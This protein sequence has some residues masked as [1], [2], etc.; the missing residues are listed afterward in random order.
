MLAEPNPDRGKYIDAS[1]HGTAVASMIIGERNGLAPNARIITVMM[2]EGS[3]TVL[4]D[5]LFKIYDDIIDRFKGVPIVINLSSGADLDTGLGNAQW[6]KPFYGNHARSTVRIFNSYKKLGNVAITMA[7]GNDPEDEPVV[8]WPQQLGMSPGLKDFAITVGGVDDDNDWLAFGNT[9][10]WLRIWAPAAEVLVPRTG[11]GVRKNRWDGVK[12]TSFAAPQV[13]GMLAYFGGLGMSMKDAV[14]TMIDY[15]YPRYDSNKYKEDA[16]MFI[17]P[18][19]G[20][21]GIG[22]NGEGILSKGVNM[23]EIRSIVSSAKS[24]KQCETSSSSSSTSTSSSSSSETSSSSESS[25]DTS[26]TTTS[27]STETT[28]TSDEASP[29][30][31]PEEFE[32]EEPK[33]GTNIPILYQGAAYFVVGAA[34][35]G[36]II[37]LIV[38]LTNHQNVT[39][40]ATVTATAG[41][42]IELNDL[43]PS[44]LL[45]SATWPMAPTP[46]RR[47][48]SK[49]TTDTVHM[50]ATLTEGK[51]AIGPVLPGQTGSVPLVPTRTIH[52]KP[53]VTT[54]EIPGALPS[55]IIVCHPMSTYEK[56]PAYHRTEYKYVDRNLVSR[57]IPEVC[58]KDNRPPESGS[59]RKWWN[60]VFY[61]GSP[62]QF[63]LQL[64]WKSRYPDDDECREEF[65][66]LLDSCDVRPDNP[67]NWTAGGS[68]QIGDSIYRIQPGYIWRR[69]PAENFVS[70]FRHEERYNF[71]WM[72]AEVK[73]TVWGYGW[74]DAYDTTVNLEGPEDFRMELSD[75]GLFKFD[76]EL[77]DRQEDNVDTGG[78]KHKSRPWEW[79]AEFSM[80]TDEGNDCV[81]DVLRRFSGSQNVTCANDPKNNMEK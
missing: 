61:P 76:W 19:N 36:G 33:W 3:H 60:K 5:G 45:V 28:T 67:R 29:S 34:I 27:T 80:K 47:P 15:A 37:A 24:R 18:Y 16:G 53:L 31:S 38:E 48:A 62:E 8:A 21:Y 42:T 7:A 17:V 57:A 68:H 64:A 59:S 71:Q 63:T 39:V 55:L 32:I 72:F 12:G 26:S 11:K 56:R 54:R 52:G 50:T 30:P 70:C 1:G 66:E 13:A 23:K 79:R 75:C 69:D 25:S 41:Q 10:P 46:T 74:N 9:S 58:Q 6:R 73:Y 4:I 78:V 44:S 49:P 22:C 20:A 81:E 43:I 14:Q 65:Q 51:P 40:N 2:G 77:T 35:A